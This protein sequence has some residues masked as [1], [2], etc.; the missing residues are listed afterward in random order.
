MVAG[1]ASSG[2][3]V[4]SR[5][6]VPVDLGAMTAQLTGLSSGMRGSGHW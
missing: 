6:R 2:E 1:P 5:R 4:W 3:H